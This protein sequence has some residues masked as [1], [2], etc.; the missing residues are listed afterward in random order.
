MT[1][2][3]SLSV[4]NTGS[5]LNNPTQR[6]MRNVS[7]SSELKGTHSPLQRSLESIPVL[8]TSFL[9]HQPQLHNVV[10]RQVRPN[11]NPLLGH[12]HALP[13]GEYTRLR[14]RLGHLC[15]RPATLTPSSQ[16]AGECT[17]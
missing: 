14:L 3:A 17:G 15:V 9:W 16:K 11:G 12:L 6:L 13:C 1:A 5:S 4:E 8:L 2:R 7:R 10:D